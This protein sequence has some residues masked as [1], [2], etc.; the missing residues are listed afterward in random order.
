MPMYGLATITLIKKL[1][2]QYKQVCYA[3]DSAAIGNIDYLGE[4]WDMMNHE[5]P[6]YGY[7]SNTLK[8]WLVTKDQY[9]E[10]DAT[11]FA[12]TGVKIISDGMIYLEA[13]L[14]SNEFI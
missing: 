12:D 3:D 13:A 5:G 8:T 2:G 1:E 7:F 6:S 14:D 4:W 11:V 9:Q 10:K